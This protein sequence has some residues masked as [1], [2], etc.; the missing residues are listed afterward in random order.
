MPFLNASPSSYGDWLINVSPRMIL[1]R[2]WESHYAPLAGA[3]PQTES[4]DHVLLHGEVAEIVWMR[5]HEFGL[6]FRGSWF[7][8]DLF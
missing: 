5:F 8:S 4:L 2:V 1:F 7:F 6:T 3:V